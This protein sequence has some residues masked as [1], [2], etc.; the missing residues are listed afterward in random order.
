MMMKA[1]EKEKKRKEEKHFNQRAAASAA[2][3]SNGNSTIQRPV[4]KENKRIYVHFNRMKSA[5]DRQR[6]NENFG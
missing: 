4:K 1:H 6:W 5:M 3:Y 2:T